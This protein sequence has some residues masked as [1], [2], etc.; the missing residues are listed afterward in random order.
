MSLAVTLLACAVMTDA[1]AREIHAHPS[2]YS[3]R[4]AICAMEQRKQPPAPLP[5]NPSARFIA[6]NPSRYSIF[7]VMRAVDELKRARAGA[8]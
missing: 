8:R 7:E 3:L 5:A 4:E 2:R 1:Q 6:E